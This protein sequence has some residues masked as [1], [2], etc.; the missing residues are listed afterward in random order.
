[1]PA[2][3]C[4]KIGDTITDPNNGTPV[5]NICAKIRIEGTIGQ[6]KT[7]VN[8][9]FNTILDYY[10]SE[11]ALDAGKAPLSWDNLIYRFNI[12]VTDDELAGLNPSPQYTNQLFYEK[13]KEMLLKPVS[14]GG[15]GY[16]NVTEI[17]A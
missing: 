8:N 4:L 12:S 9:I 17:F 3:K 16:T 11:S 6:G 13:V 10:Y 15:S 5:V 7:G 2:V 14:E 1:M